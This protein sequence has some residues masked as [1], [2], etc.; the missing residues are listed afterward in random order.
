[1]GDLFHFQFE[2]VEL[3]LDFKDGIIYLWYIP[4]PSN[5]DQFQNDTE[6]VLSC[7]T[8]CGELLVSLE[9]DGFL[10]DTDPSSV[11]QGFRAFSLSS[12]SKM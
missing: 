8:Q 2:S 1:M 9:E 3:S 10:H 5:S 11:G 4:F 12:S 7:K 6:L